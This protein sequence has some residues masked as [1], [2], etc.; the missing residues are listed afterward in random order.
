MAEVKDNKTKFYIGQPRPNEAVLG[1]LEKGSSIIKGA[2][3]P[4]AS[5]IGGKQIIA[6]RSIVWG[7]RLD[8]NGN[9]PKD[10]VKLQPNDK[11]YRGKVD[12]NVKWGTDGGMPITTRYKSGSAS[13]DYDYQVLQL[14]MK[15]FED[16]LE[17]NYL[18]LPMGEYVL[19][20]SEE[21]KKLMLLTHHEN[22]DSVCR[23]PDVINGSIRLVKSF[24]SKK[25]QVVMIDKEFQAVKIVQDA[26]T[27]DHLVVLK[28]I[29]SDKVDIRYDES[30]ETSLFENIILWVKQNAE[31]FLECIQAYNIRVS[32]VIEKFRSY[33]AFDYTTDGKLMGG[34]DKKEIL[35][36]GIDAKGEAMIDYLFENRMEPEVFDAINKM[37]VIAQKFK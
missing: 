15:R 29:M 22:I 13:I 4:M 5:P 6:N 23:N 34:Q 3:T 27:F 18:D 8:A 21:A 11:N 12:F 17:D 19:F 31:P 35:V 2:S 20:D 16:D 24:E 14:G 28:T 7:I 36:T 32:D 26:T 37:T 10:G 1:Q 33:K 30:D 25:E 9:K